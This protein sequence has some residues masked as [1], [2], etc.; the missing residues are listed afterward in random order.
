MSQKK[1]SQRPKLL[2]I[3]YTF[4]NGGGAEKVLQLLVNNIPSDSYDVT[5]QEVEAFDK[6]LSLN[7][8]II[9]R[10]AFFEQNFP[11]ATFKPLNHFLLCN[12]PSLLKSI[13]H[14]N[15][16]DVVI[17]FNYQLPSFM[18]P[19]FD[20]A[21]KIAWFHSDIYDL[22]EK[23]CTWEKQKQHDVWK[24]VDKIVTISNKSLKSLKDVF[25][26]FSDL[27]TIIHNGLDFSEIENLKN[28]ELDCK[29]PSTDF[30]V[31]IGRLDERKNFSLLIKAFAELRKKNTAV[32]LCLIGQ[33][34]LYSELRSLAES[35]NV[36]EYVHF[37]GFQKNPIKYLKNAKLLCVTSLSEGWPTV[38]MESMALGIPFVTT[39][40]AGASEE[41]CDDGKCGLVSKYNPKEY[42]DAV[43]NL[44]T[45]EKLYKTMSS[46]CKKTIQ[47][48]SAENYAAEFCK[49]L[50]ELDIKHSEKSHKK[51]INIF[52]YIIY[53]LLYSLNIG[54]LYNRAKII[55]KRIKEKRFIK[56]IKNSVY[57]TGLIILL[58]FT[59]ILKTVFFPWYIHS[60]NKK[61]NSGIITK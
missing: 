47:Q 43:E 33:G 16:F 18:L 29:V 24:N 38:V 5:I 17:T 53:W 30:I 42:A 9:L 40:V 44:L 35:L 49:L 52:N 8:N 31:G 54:D 20:E 12:F 28:E 32:E 60:I 7:D 27:S 11:N 46:N 48:Y 41:L 55:C 51:N 19:A 34:D 25:P 10:K 45:D 23:N 36:N 37:L 15:N 61:Y 13:F 1:D 26:D 56:I 58:P 39:P 2:F 3:P 4:T 22:N 50:A 14:L 59:F 21:K 57:F 6:S